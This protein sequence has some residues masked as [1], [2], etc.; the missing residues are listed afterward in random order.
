MI[1]KSNNKKVLVLMSGGVDSSTTAAL[2]C[3]KGYAVSGVY[4]KFYA[5]GDSCWANEMKD[6]GRVAAKLHIPFQVWDVTKEYKKRVLKNFYSEYSAGRTPNP[7]VLCNSEI[8]F[9]IALDKAMKL[10]YDYVA[11]G[12]YARVHNP[13][14]PPLNLRG[15]DELKQFPPL[16]VRGGQGELCYLYTGVDKKKDQSYFLW[17]LTQKQLAHTLFP[18]GGYTKTRVRKMAK[19]F[20]LHNAEKKDS[21][22]VCFLGKI[23]LKEFL[24]SA[25]S[26]RDGTPSL[27]DGA[28]VDVHGKTLGRHSGLAQ[29]TIGQRHGGNI[30]DGQG[31]YFVIA[32]DIKKNALIVAN[33]QDEKNY[34]AVSCTIKGGN[35]LNMKKN[36][37]KARVRY[38]GELY[39]VKINGKIIKFQTPVRAVA[40]GQS[41]V[42]YDGDRVVGGGII[43]KVKLVSSRMSESSRILPNNS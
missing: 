3:K 42:F 17:R 40:A 19:E 11:T 21:Q 5:G 38:R 14:Q 7:D 29:F 34:R 4:L 13:S 28:I 24:S 26:L 12:H 18:I 20:G 15:G 25:P 33:E 1:H 6:A 16:K 10:G 2:L 39:K 41:I 8:K 36:N 43:D 30:T 22:G 27:S 23:N 32:K 35:W 37:L 31:P 9:G